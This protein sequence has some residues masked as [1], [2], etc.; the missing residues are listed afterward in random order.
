MN[1]EP[2]L[3]L[4]GPTEREGR[5]HS[6]VSA[7]CC[8]WP[9]IRFPRRGLF[10]LLSWATPSHFCL[11]LT[12][13]HLNSPHHSRSPSLYLCSQLP[14]YSSS[15]PSRSQVQAVARPSRSSAGSWL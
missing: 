4:P 8:E 2:A 11:H 12:F 7:L 15:P 9:A 1:S 14:F 3:S 10:A 6:P 5:G 13:F